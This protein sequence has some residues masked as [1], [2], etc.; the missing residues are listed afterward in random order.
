MEGPENQK[1]RRQ[2]LIYPT[3]KD[4]V[5]APKPFSRSAAKRDSVLA[6]GSIEHLQ[7]Y[8]T[9]AGIQAKRKYVIFYFF[10]DAEE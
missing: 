6:L 9:K 1:K 7:H 4:S 2:T 3:S 8:F 5:R 10:E